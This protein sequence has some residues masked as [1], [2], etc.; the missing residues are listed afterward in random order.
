MNPTLFR[1]LVVLVPG[2]ILFRGFPFFWFLRSKSPYSLLQLIGA[3]SVIV[4]VLPR[5]RFSR[6]AVRTQFRWADFERKTMENT[7]GVGPSPGRAPAGFGQ[8]SGG[9]DVR[10]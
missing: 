6:P 2:A 9:C 5:L 7:M 10:F 3:G 1:A 4:V 8:G